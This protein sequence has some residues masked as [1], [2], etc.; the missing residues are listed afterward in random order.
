MKRY[1]CPTCKEFKYRWQLKLVD[2]TRT[3]FYECKWCHNRNIYKAEDVMNKLIEMNPK[4]LSDRRVMKY[5][6]SVKIVDKSK[7]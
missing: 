2:D 3:A 5:R 7:K 4:S 1:Y 6:S